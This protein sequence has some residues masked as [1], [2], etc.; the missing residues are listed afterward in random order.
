M[1][2]TEWYVRMCFIIIA[3]RKR[4]WTILRVGWFLLHLQHMC[5]YEHT[6]MCAPISWVT[7]PFTLLIVLKNLLMGTL[8]LRILTV[9]VRSRK[10]RDQ[11][12]FGSAGLQKTP[13]LG[14]KWPPSDFLCLF[15][16]YFPISTRLCR[17]HFST[18]HIPILLTLYK[19]HDWFKD[20]HF[21][22][23]NTHRENKTGELCYSKPWTVERS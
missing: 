3:L 10:L 23:C 13:K 6:Q 22:P 19:N 9:P 2:D 20:N 15:L 18:G 7:Q 16:F 4:V 21:Q 5:A 11:V 17:C 8:S 1:L 14:P 12:V